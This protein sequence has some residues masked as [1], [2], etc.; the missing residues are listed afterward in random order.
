M[1]YLI[2]IVAFL[3]WWTTLSVEIVALRKFT[4]I[5][6][7]NS[8]ST[9][10]I[11]GVILLALSYWYYIWWKISANNKKLEKRLIINLLISSIYYFFITFLFTEIILQ[12][13]LS[14]SWSYFISVLLSS[15]ILFFVPVFLASQTIPLLS[16]LLK[17]NNSWEKMWKLLFFSTI[18][19]FIGSISTSIILFPLIWVFKTGVISAIIL[20][21]CALILSIFILKR[22]IKIQFLSLILFWFF[23][24]FNIVF[25]LNNMTNKFIIFEKAN[26]YH[27]I[28]IYDI[29]NELWKKRIFSL[30]WW[31][32]SWIDLKDKK[33][34][35]E[36]IKE[37]EE[38]VIELK[39]KNILVIWAAGFT[40]PND[41]SK[42]DFVEN[43]DVVDIDPELKDI[44]EKYFLQEK[45]SEK[46]IFF[47]EPSRFFVN[48]KIEKLNNY[49]KYDLILVDAYSWKSLP[50]Q[51]LTKEFFENLNK[52]GDNIFLN[53]IIDR[54]LGSIFSRNLLTT[55]NNSFN[56][57][58]L[59]DVNIWIWWF[60]NLIVSNKKYDKYLKNKITSWNIYTDDKN[61]IELDLFELNEE[62][63]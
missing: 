11:L 10:I 51:V 32:S 14:F 1:K 4:P 44:S 17:W 23:L 21:F 58:Y 56:E 12:N 6:G 30:E 49:K 27:N 46:I 19:S 24:Y 28:K 41:I 38:R 47:P 45:L 33:S 35:F 13:I 43:I 63:Y 16:E 26:S 54:D 39:A 60:T 8:I 34:F 25:D 48:K 50:P 20:T 22:N 3:E 2:Y 18:G 55:L 31:Y 15:I 37:V 62:K 29:E 53:I 5:I 40:F 59:K 61:S 7:S 9:S 57:V 42:Y 52:I 36:Y